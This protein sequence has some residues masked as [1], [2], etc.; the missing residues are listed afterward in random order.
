MMLEFSTHAILCV[1]KG[2]HRILSHESFVS[3]SSQDAQ[4]LWLIWQ[5]I[6]AHADVLRGFHMV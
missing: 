3:L 6:I 1:Y 2:K 4:K 5:V